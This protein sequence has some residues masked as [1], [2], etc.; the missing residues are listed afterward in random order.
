MH[1]WEEMII[2]EGCDTKSLDLRTPWSKKQISYEISSR[3]TVRYTARRGQCSMFLYT[4]RYWHGHGKARSA[5]EVFHSHASK[6]PRYCFKRMPH[7]MK[8]W[9]SIKRVLAVTVVTEMPSLPV[10]RLPPSILLMISLM[11]DRKNPVLS[12]KKKRLERFNI[13][14]DITVRQRNNT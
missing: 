8:K 2:T 13:F 1:K 5:L 7:V 14:S 3:F 12:L 6:V 11:S 4:A 10:C 9:D